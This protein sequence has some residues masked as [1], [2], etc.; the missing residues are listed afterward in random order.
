VPEFQQNFL[1][2]ISLAVTG[3]PPGGGENCV[4]APVAKVA[5]S[6]KAIPKS[7]IL[8]GMVAISLSQWR[9]SPPALLV[10]L[11]GN[12]LSLF[13]D[14]LSSDKAVFEGGV[15]IG[16]ATTLIL[17]LLRGRHS[18]P[19]RFDKQF[20]RLLHW[21]LPDSGGQNNITASGLQLVR[22]GGQQGNSMRALIAQAQAHPGSP[23]LSTR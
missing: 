19:G 14:H 13:V 16:E 4:D 3:L 9:R 5:V 17:L 22:N 18:I 1:P 21:S 23:A 20:Q 11:T 2:E 10:S 6:A 8:A 7:A 12:R 15:A